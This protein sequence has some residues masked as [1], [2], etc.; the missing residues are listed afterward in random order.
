MQVLLVALS[1]GAPL[2]PGSGNTFPLSVPEMRWQVNFLR[3]E[4]G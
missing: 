1:P 3:G 4:E 2:K